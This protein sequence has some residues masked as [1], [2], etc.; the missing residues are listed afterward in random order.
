M[1]WFQIIT[2]LVCYIEINICVKIFKL[3][4]LEDTGGSTATEMT[5]RVMSTL[6]TLK[7]CTKYTLKGKRANKSNFG[8][9]RIC[10][11]IESK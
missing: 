7:L 9:L 6:F 2:N 11:V 3:Q 10:K 1:F 5:R 4:I 8:A